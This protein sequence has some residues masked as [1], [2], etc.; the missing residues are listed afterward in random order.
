MFFN[1]LNLIQLVRHSKDILLII[2]ILIL[3]VTVTLV[4]IALIDLIIRLG[5]AS[6]QILDVLC[7]LKMRTETL[8]SFV[9]R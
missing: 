7:L 8:F 4:Y 3:Y 1:I 5:N 9:G 6:L 2:L